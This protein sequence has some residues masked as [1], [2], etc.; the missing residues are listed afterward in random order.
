[1]SYGHGGRG[2][3]YGAAPED[4]RVYRLLYSRRT[5]AHQGEP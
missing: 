3:Q 2:E 4:K 1:M 5:I